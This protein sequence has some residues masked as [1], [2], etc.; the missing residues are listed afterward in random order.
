MKLLDYLIQNNPNISRN[1]LKGYL[2]KGAVFA[3]GT[4]Q[5][6]FDFEVTPQTHIE[7]VRGTRK[8]DHR[9]A[10]ER[11]MRKFATIVFEDRWLMVVEKNVGILSVPSGHHVFCLKTLLD[12]YLVRK[13]EKSTT[14]I[15]HRLDKL[16]SGLMIFA[17]SRQVQEYFTN[18]W[19]NVI[20]DRRYY[21]VCDG[22]PSK[23][24]GTFE[25]FLWDD[26]FYFT[27]SSNQE[28]EGSKLAITHYKTIKSNNLYSLLDCKLETGRKN[29]IR[30][31]L[32]QMGCPVVGDLK[33]GNGEDPKQRL[34]L[35]A[36]RICFTHPI[37]HQE[38][39]FETPLPQEFQDLLNSTK[40]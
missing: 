21:A 30:V 16:T 20:S 23:P 25:S 9:S 11:N 26:K 31:H 10:P 8:P 2:T 37:T 28:V 6:H 24:Q 40:R 13:G 7:L 22:C 32:Q 4:P 14:H 36:Y 5:T 17:K 15:V 33:Y 19:H 12:E 29:Q 27:H 39:K 1:K 38:L 3:D 34:C 18:D 35:H